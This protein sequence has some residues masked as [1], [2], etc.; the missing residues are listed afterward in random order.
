MVRKISLV[1]LT[2]L[3]KIQAQQQLAR[4]ASLSTR[5]L[6][7]TEITDQWYRVAGTSLKRCRRVVRSSMRAVFY[8][9]FLIIK[10]LSSCVFSDEMFMRLLIILSQ[11]DTRHRYTFSNL[12]TIS[13]RSH[14]CIYTVLFKYPRIYE[15]KYTVTLFKK[16]VEEK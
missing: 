8:S 7:T 2:V 4:L 5:T 1:H 15:S 14:Q 6:A 10:Q 12:S 13:H 3:F 16:E 11:Q 9:I